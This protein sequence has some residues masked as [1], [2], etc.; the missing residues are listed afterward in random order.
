MSTRTRSGPTCLPCWVASD[1]SSARLSHS[2]YVVRFHIP[3]WLILLP[4]QI[5]FPR[6]IAKEA[7]YKPRQKTLSQNSRGVHVG[8]KNNQNQAQQI[9]SVPVDVKDPGLFEEQAL[10]QTQSYVAPPPGPEPEGEQMYARP[11]PAA[12]GR[13]RIGSAVTP[14]ERAAATGYGAW[15]RAPEGGGGGAWEMVDYQEYQQHGVILPTVAPRVPPRRQTALH[16]M[17]L[18]YTSPIGTSLF[19]CVARC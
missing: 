10:P 15:D 19:E 12:A 17:V 14:R 16:P 9:T 1:A 6:S 3:V 18:S 4:W 2:W 5:F 7:G 8:P 11:P 13:I